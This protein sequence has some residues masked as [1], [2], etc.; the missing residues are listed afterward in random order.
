MTSPALYA[1]WAACVLVVLPIAYAGDPYVYGFT[2]LAVASVTAVFGL[3]GVLVAV[4]AGTLSVTAR[5]VII[6]SIVAAGAAA[7]LALR[8]LGTFNW[9]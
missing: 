8:V 4:F 2:V 1:G 7:A 3:A 9:A 6:V 5:R